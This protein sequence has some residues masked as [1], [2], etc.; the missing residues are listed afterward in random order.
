LSTKDSA[1][2][3]TQP[4]GGASR[5]ANELLVSA[6][7][8]VGYYT[9]LRRGGTRAVDIAGFTLV[10]RPSVYD[11]R[12]YRA[13]ALF[14]EF[15]GGLALAGK[16]VADLGTGS[17]LQ[18]LAA[19]RAGASSVMALDVNPAAVAAT[20]GNARLAGFGDRVTAMVSDLFSAIEAGPRFDVILT[21]PPFCEGRAWDTADRA[22]RAGDRYEDIAPLFRQARE[23][24][25]PGGAVYMI[26][27][28]HADL[29]LVSRLVRDAG[30]SLRIAHRQR[31]LLETLVIYEMRL[32]AGQPR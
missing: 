23:R 13:P 24:L 21:N 19:A 3:G 17:G 18:A 7:H 4:R 28:S 12:F 10:I 5:L 32:V 27:S 9:V 14:A 8:F 11:P 16:A 26:L 15:I 2:L 22:W 20:V 31:V 6:L 30:F 25:K 29:E 1:L